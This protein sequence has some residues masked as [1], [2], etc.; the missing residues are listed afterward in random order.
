MFVVLLGD[1]T[2]R[3]YLEGIMV[4]RIVWVVIGGSNSTAVTGGYCEI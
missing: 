2:E 3:Q 4:Y 1:V